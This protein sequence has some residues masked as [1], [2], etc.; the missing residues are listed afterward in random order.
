MFALDILEGSTQPCVWFPQEVFIPLIIEDSQT[1]WKILKF[2][3][4]II[5][6]GRGNCCWAKKVSSQMSI[7]GNDKFHTKQVMSPIYYLL[8]A[9]ET[10]QR[11]N[12][13]LVYVLMLL[14]CKCDDKLCKHTTSSINLCVI[15]D[16]K[17]YAC[18]VSSLYKSKITCMVSFLYCIV[19]SFY[20]LRWW[21]LCF[22]WS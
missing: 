1:H 11:H 16:V 7:R 5:F 19:S 20:T 8:Q 18:M 14:F 9:I 4:N 22:L 15:G 6:A 3:Y 10:N 12:L 13:V 17:E 21:Y 2:F